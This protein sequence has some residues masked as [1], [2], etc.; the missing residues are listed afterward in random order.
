MTAPLPL[1]ARHS[2]RRLALCNRINAQ[3]I[4]GRLLDEGN[5][6]VAILRT[7]EPLQPLRVVTEA[8]AGDDVELEMRIA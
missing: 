1:P 7:G 2:P 6:S 8:R 4:A 3:R 5:A